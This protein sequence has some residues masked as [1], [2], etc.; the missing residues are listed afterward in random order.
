MVESFPQEEQQRRQSIISQR[1]NTPSAKTDP[2][3][4]EIISIDD[5]PDE[6][7]EEEESEEYSSGSNFFDD[8]WEDSMDYDDEYNGLPG[9]YYGGYGS[10]YKCGRTGHWSNGCPNR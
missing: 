9:V 8:D 4:S 2:K 10:C 1:Q 3:V 6:L 7:E 5:S